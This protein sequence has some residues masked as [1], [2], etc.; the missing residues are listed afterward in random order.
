MRTMMIAALGGLAALTATVPAFAQNDSAPA[1]S[2]QA[3][4][5]GQAKA[6][7]AKDSRDNMSNKADVGKAD[8]VICRKIEQIGSRV[9]ARRVCATA[10]QWAAMKQEDR[11]GLEKIQTQRYH[12]NGS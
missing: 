1:D 8:R 3:A 6:A 4:S 12:G 11:E 9:H 7:D 2:A 5:D 10:E